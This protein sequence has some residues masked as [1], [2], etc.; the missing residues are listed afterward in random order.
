MLCIGFTESG[1]VLSGDSNGTLTAWDPETVR[2]TRVAHRVHD[3]RF[4]LS[5]AWRLTGSELW[6]DRAG[7]SRCAP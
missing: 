5:L 4:L 3:V 6:F 1:E 7:S 2:P